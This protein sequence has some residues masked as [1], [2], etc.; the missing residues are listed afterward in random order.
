ME[1]LMPCITLSVG[2][3]TFMFVFTYLPQAAVLSLVNGPLAALTTILLVLE[4][5]S[6]LINVLSKSFL[7]ED[8]LVDTFDAVSLSYATFR[9]HRDHKRLTRAYIGS[10]QRK[11]DFPGRPRP[12]SEIW[13][14]RL[15]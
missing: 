10:P 15:L 2:V 5:S 13:L 3:V 9:Q 12:R 6:T 8:A 1:K 11:H 4:E 14:Q 7:I